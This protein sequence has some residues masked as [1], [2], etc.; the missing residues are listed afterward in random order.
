MDIPKPLCVTGQSSCFHYDGVQQVQAIVTLP[1]SDAP[2]SHVQPPRRFQKIC[3]LSAALVFHPLPQA[4]FQGRFQWKKNK[5]K[6]ANPL[7]RKGFPICPY[8]AIRAHLHK[9]SPVQWGRSE[10]RAGTAGALG[11][12]YYDEHLRPLYEGSETQLRPTAGQ[13]SQR[14]VKNFPLFQ[15]VREKTR[16]ST[17]GLRVGQAEMPDISRFF[18]GKK[19]KLRFEPNVAEVLLC[20]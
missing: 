20:N 5:D 7:R 19:N 18:K 3:P 8:Y 11:R 10:G 2:G 16:E 17:C 15:P 4:P 14:G 6:P 9:Q 1:Y 12:Q 13:G